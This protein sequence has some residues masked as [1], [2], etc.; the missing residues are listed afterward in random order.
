MKHTVSALALC[1]AFIGGPALAADLPYR[2]AAPPAPYYEP[3]PI[4]TWTGLY[5]GVNAGGAFGGS[6]S[7]NTSAY[8]LYDLPGTA[9][10]AAFATS[11]NSTAALSNSSF[12][13]GGQIGYNW[14]FNN[15]FVVGLE[16]DFQG[17]DGSANA[18]SGG[19]GFDP[20][21]GAT[22]ITTTQVQKSLDYLGTVRGRLG[23]LV[24]PTLLVYATGGLAYGGANVNTSF[25][26]VD[27]ASVFAPGFGSGS[28]S[29]TQVGYT[30][31]G[32]L[33]WMFAHNWSAKLEYLYY[34]LGTVTTAGTSLSGA[35][36]AG[37]MQWAY[38]P[39]TS[40]RF[41]GHIVRAGLNYHFNWAAPAPVVAK[42]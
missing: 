25:S 39:A 19:V 41:D 10:G 18:A 20:L 23:F 26:S 9:A 14:Q 6:S 24:T 37:A 31:G 30:V 33:E 15:S 27:A 13:G 11:A 21:S 28:V 36:G 38:A 4:A 29:S 8:D 1:A 17:V 40:A 22:P 34:D 35:N 2:K 7:A 12:I 32:G 3:A 5:V 42:Y 16:A